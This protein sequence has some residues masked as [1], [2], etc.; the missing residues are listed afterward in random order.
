MPR[1][2]YSNRGA[3]L[4]IIIPRWVAYGKRLL[5]IFIDANW[6]K[7]VAIKKVSCI[8]AGGCWYFNQN[9]SSRFGFGK[10]TD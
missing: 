7:T 8:E 9:E 2:R 5:P 1:V 10:P 4:K 3:R 6:G